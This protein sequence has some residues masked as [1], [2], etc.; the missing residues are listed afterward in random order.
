MKLITVEAKLAAEHL[1]QATNAILAQ[2][3][4]VRSMAGCAHY[5]LTT[6]N[7]ML[8]IVQ[9]WQSEADFDAYRESTSFK[10]LIGQLA[11]LFSE[12]PVTTVGTVDTV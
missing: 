4:T 8:T 1:D 5:A 11:P 10:G 3:D 2:A 7:G 12:P 6:G 9:R